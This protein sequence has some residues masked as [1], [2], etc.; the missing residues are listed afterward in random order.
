[1]QERTTKGII[2][3]DDEYGFTYCVS[4]IEYTEWEDESFRYLFRPDYSLIDLLPVRIFQGIP[5]LN[6]D[7]RKECYVRE[8]IVPVFI[9]ERTPGENRVDLW[10][11]LEKYDMDYLN[12]LEWLIRSDMRQWGDE[13]YVIRER[14]KAVQVSSLY[15]FGNRSAVICRKALEIICSGENLQTETFRIDDTN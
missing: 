2:C 12:R 6:L 10:E 9:S 7:L 15:D 8:N 13:F 5:G 4:E 1:M 11:L 3:V 14:P